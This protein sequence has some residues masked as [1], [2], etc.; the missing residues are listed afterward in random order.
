MDAEAMEASRF[1]AQSTLGYDNSHIESV[2]N[3]GI[4]NWIDN[5]ITLNQSFIA[6]EVWT[7]Y[8][9]INASIIANG[10]TIDQFNFRPSWVDFNYAWWQV[11][12]T[13]D[14][15]L[16]H[17]VATALSEIFVISKNSDLGETGD[18]LGSFYDMLGTHAFGN[19][20]DLLLDVSM[21]PCMGHY[22]SH[23]NN[24]KADP[25]NNTHPDENYAREIM[26]LFSIGLY[27]LNQDGSRMLDLNGDFIPTYDQDD[28]KNFAKIFTGLGVAGTIPSPSD[29]N[30]YWGRSIYGANMQIPMIM[31]PSQHEP[32]PKYLLNG[33]TVPTGQAGL[34]DIEDA[35]D[36]LYNHPNVGP[37]IGYRL[38]QRLVKSNPSPA[39]VGRVSAVFANNGFG[40]RGDMAAVVKAILMD[41]E[42]RDCSY[43]QLQSSSRLREPIVRYM[44]F[45]RAVDKNNPNDYYW[46]VNES[47]Y[48]GTKQDVLRSPSVFN[49]FLPDHAPVGD[50]DNADL[51][52]P[53][54]YIHNTRT[55]VG[56][57]NEVNTW[58]S[59]WGF[60]LNTWEGEHMTV[61]QTE[62]DKTHY[63]SMAAEPEIL[64]NELDR[65]FTH[66]TLSDRNRYII[67]DAIRK[68][69]DY[70]SGDDHLAYRVYLATYLIMISPDYAVMR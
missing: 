38:I 49:F 12:L 57:V 14:D 5:Q 37:F 66:G 55:S 34:Q 9:T 42:A 24:P 13:N 20:R 60:L 68:I 44:H 41:E 7:I 65:V 15:L 23:L 62:F 17:R 61:T 67:L 45:A 10:G 22:L 28:I 29:Q 43:Q 19:Y 4:E 36:N 3:S 70:N 25:V 53:E 11:N 33:V 6:P 50:I 40:V 56:Y 39:Y 8:N 48:D 27:E 47:F 63:I 1:L 59:H 58:T 31:Y 35:I 46:N 54:F 18:G 32:G 51:V 64:I 2:V 21:H 30:I 16:R 69:N 52:A 26:Q